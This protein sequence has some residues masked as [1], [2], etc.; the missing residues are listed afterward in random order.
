MVVHLYGKSVELV[1]LTRKRS[2]LRLSEGGQVAFC[3]SP[4]GRGKQYQNLHN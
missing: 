1:Y 3:P 2:C 4:I